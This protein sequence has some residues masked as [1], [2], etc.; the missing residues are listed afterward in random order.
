MLVLR[1]LFILSALA[2][3]LSGG[4]YVFTK[5]RRYLTLGWQIAKFSA[6]ALLVF[7]LLYILERYVLIGIRILT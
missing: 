2:I 3:A 7:V 5:N 6:L 4:M 1:L